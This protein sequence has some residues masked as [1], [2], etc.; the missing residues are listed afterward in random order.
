M[1][2]RAELACLPTPRH[3]FYLLAPLITMGSHNSLALAAGFGS[4]F[5]HEYLVRSQ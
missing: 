3:Q 4:L 1:G 2:F 5:G